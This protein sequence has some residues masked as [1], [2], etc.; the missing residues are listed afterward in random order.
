MIPSGSKQADEYSNLEDDIGLDDFCL[1][2]PAAVDNLVCP[3][4]GS[5]MVLRES[6]KYRKPFYGCER[7]PECRAAHGA[8]TDGRPLGIPANADTKR[9]RMRAHRV[10]D[11]LWQAKPGEE[12]IM[13]RVEAYRWMG[14]ILRL[15]ST[16]AHIGRFTREQCEKL[17]QKVLR[18]YPEAA[19]AWDRLLEDPFD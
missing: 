7:Y 9:A 14:T 1:T 12:P 2:R 11:A 6:K 17:V 18:K 16:E 19:N 13:S 15:P 5:H 10:F 3:E 8:H 4:C